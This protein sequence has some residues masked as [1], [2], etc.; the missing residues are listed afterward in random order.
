MITISLYKNH[1]PDIIILILPK[2]SHDIVLCTV[3]MLWR[4]HK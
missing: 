3:P 1:K 2:L 4:P